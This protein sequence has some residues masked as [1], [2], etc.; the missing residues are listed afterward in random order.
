VDKLELL[1]RAVRSLSRKRPPL[2]LGRHACVAQ[3]L[4]V[5]DL[6]HPTHP[7]HDL[8]T[9]KL[10]ER[11][12]VEMPKP[13]MPTPCLIISTSGK[14]EG[15]SHLHVKHIQSA[16]LAVDLG[17]KATAAVPDL[18]HPSVNLHSRA[19]L[20]ELVEADDGVPKGRD[21]VDPMEQLVLAGL[22]HEHHGLDAVDLHRGLIAELDGAP[23]AAVQVI[24]VP[25]TP[26]HVVRGTAVEV[27]SLELVVVG[28]VAEESLCAWL[29]DV[30]QGRR[31]ER[32]CG[33]G[34]RGS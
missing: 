10:S 28:A 32:R 1:Q 6:R 25:N 23:G 8:L 5:V 14:A 7:T 31:G 34:V 21:V 12:E 24:E 17:E 2:V 20:V 22:S 29:V 4:N 27:P 9:P 15:P 33:V 16:A 30:E 3:L 26:D 11:L 13:L 19:A 18:E